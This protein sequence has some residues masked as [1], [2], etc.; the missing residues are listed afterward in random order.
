ML[1]RIKRKA[2]FIFI[3]ALLVI[4]IIEAASFFTVR[5][6]QTK[7]VIYK[8]SAFEYYDNY[9]LLRDNL[10]GWPS[11]DHFG[12]GDWHDNK[13]GRITPS[14]PDEATHEDCI[15]LYGDS[16]TWS[17]EVEHEHAW[18]NILSRLAN[19][20]VANYGVGAYGSDQAFLRFQQKTDDKSPIVFL[21]H[22]SENILRNINQFR[23]LLYP[24]VGLGFKPRF[25]LDEDNRL[26]LIPIPA[27]DPPHYEDFVL[28][29][30]KY[31]EHEYFIPGGPAGTTIAS[32]PYTLAVIKSLKHFHIQAELRDEPWYLEFYQKDYPSR[33]LDTTTAI[34]K[35]FH[36]EA[37]SMGRN[38]VVT[39]IPTGQDLQFFIDQQFWPYDS[40]IDELARQ[41]VPVFNFGPGIIAH[42]S[43]RDPC[44]LFDDCFAHYNEEGYKVL[45]NLA[46]ELLLERQLLDRL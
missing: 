33:A 21:N 8:P 44:L 32:F 39:I 31:L 6:L 12:V 9:L 36:Q 45:A 25:R 10:L 40:L 29:P 23:D 3:T 4:A 27:V 16:F 34:L 30:E 46:Y 5:Y 41:G 35:A 37:L 18:G 14:F 26:E 42:T 13:G 38:P 15:S 7:G 28:H 19:C 22:L 1:P 17:S 2:L 20:R 43:N 24:G 11:S